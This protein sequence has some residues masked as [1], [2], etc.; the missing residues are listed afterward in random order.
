MITYLMQICSI[1]EYFMNIGVHTEQEAEM[2]EEGRREIVSIGEVMNTTI[3]AVFKS[4]TTIQYDL[5]HLY[6]GFV[7]ALVF[8]HKEMY[9]Y[10]FSM[11]VL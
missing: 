7:G 8:L 11:F 4:G 3:T 5:P 9:V 10:T 6:F 2:M 1:Q